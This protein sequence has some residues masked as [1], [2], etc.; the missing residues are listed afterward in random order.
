MRVVTFARRLSKP[1]R[2]LVLSALVF[3]VSPSFA[4]SAPTDIVLSDDAPSGWVN[5]PVVVTI[6]ATDTVNG[7]D[8][9]EWTLK[10][11]WGTVS[12]SG[13]VPSAE[14]TVSVASDV[15]VLEYWAYN[16][17][18]ER[19]E[20]QTAAVLVDLGAPDTRSVA[21][22]N[23]ELTLFATDPFYGM[24]AITSVFY[25]VDDGPV[26]PY[27]SPFEY[28]TPGLHE[29]E[30]WAVDRAGNTTVRTRWFY[31]ADPPEPPAEPERTA[32]RDRYETAAAAMRVE[33]DPLG[34]KTWPGVSHVVIANGE[35]RAAPD[36]L[37]AAGLSW[38]LNAPL[39]LVS[40]SRVPASTARAL[41]EIRSACASSGTC[42]RGAGY[43][44]DTWPP[45]SG[46]PCGSGSLDV[47]IVGGSSVIP[48][49]V[50]DDLA[51]LA[52]DCLH[53]VGGENRYETTWSVMQRVWVERYGETPVALVVNGAATASFFD[54]LSASTVAASKGYSIALVQRDGIP[55]PVLQMLRDRDWGRVVVIG[56]PEAVS[57]GVLRQVDELTGDAPV[58]RWWGDDRYQTA[59]AVAT[60]AVGRDWLSPTFVGVASRLP[61]ALVG[62]A[63][64]GHRGGVLM[65]SRDDALPL[66]SARWLENHDT[67]IRRCQLLGES[68][69]LSDAV[70]DQV[71]G[72]LQ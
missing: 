37:T 55:K 46:S 29:L 72:I 32:G 39:L 61:D 50:R 6:T 9:I 62:G 1:I 13:S 34:D 42:P 7:I 51:E 52:G 18:G 53:D 38:A 22:R 60:K 56:G 30:Y 19:S 26:Q 5:Y 14:A 40:S 23:A 16:G 49:S 63:A 41:Q 71:R 54:A 47:W 65:L 33:F 58:E 27:A 28:E 66:T 12:S 10:T 48:S 57:E 17:I 36:A 64:V 35:D 43:D 70:E 21:A 8:R 2:F 67:E 15:R 4:S 24:S 20:T 31:V 69:V 45:G 44:P 68:D 25:R 11:T 3:A 59:T